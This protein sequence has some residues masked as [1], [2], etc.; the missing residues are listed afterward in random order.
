MPDPMEYSDEQEFMGVCVP[1]KVSEGMT[2]EDAAAQCYAMWMDKAKSTVK[3]AGDWE[4]EVLGVPFGSPTDKDSDGQY[5]S[6]HTD[7][8]AEQFPQI[9]AVYYHGR[10]PQ[11]RPMQKPEYF[12]TAKYAR[13]DERGHWYRVVLDKTKALAQRVWEA[14]KKGIARA[15]SGSAPHLVRIEND[16]HIKE[17]AVMELSIFDAEGQ[18][19]P[20]NRHAVAMPVLKALYKDAGIEFIDNQLEAQGSGAADNK[21]NTKQENKMSEQKEGLTPEMVQA[22]I[23]AALKAERDANEAAQKAQK[24]RDEEVAAE[25]KKQVDA[26]KAEYAK[27]RRL[28]DGDGVPYVTQF[29]DRKY[30]NLSA[31]ELSL[32]LDTLNARGVKPS[33]SAMKSLAL[34]LITEKPNNERRDK[35]LR[36]IKSAMPVQML[37]ENALK[38]AEVMATSDSGNGSDW[39]G[40]AYSTE[41][42]RSIRH[43]GGIVSRIPEVTIPDG[44]SS[45]YFPLEDADPTWYKVAETTAVNASIAVP[46][47]SVTAS[48]AGTA[49]KQ[50]TVSKL[51]A[52]VLYSGEMTEDSLIQFAPQ[53][54]EQLMVSGREIMEAI[55]INGDTETGA[56]TNI[57]DIAGTPAATDWFML[58][59]GFRKLALVTNTAN[60]RS[61]GGSLSIED[62]LETM[63]LLGTAGIAASDLSKI[64]F[65]VD[66]HVHFANM[67]LPEVKTRDVYSAAVIE[68][69]FLSQAYGVPILPSWQMNKGATGAYALKAN[70]A[71]KIDLDTNT[72]NTTGAIL[73]VRF[74][75]WKL[76]YKR[77]MTME[78]T[79]FANAD[80]WEIVA[81]ARFGLG[82]R[83]TEASAISYNVGI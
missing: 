7:I 40:T 66:P 44:Y 67:T 78:V 55:V 65:I 60:S 30:D 14:A 18:R 38:A 50:I 39:V 82:Y 34:K 3:A 45:Q 10:D 43:D 4:L 1:M 80:A 32:V 37:D 74:D 61:A 24:A 76:A 46:E 47:V 11:G 64:A 26:V 15:S 72:N 2:Q 6:K 81:L 57:N 52:R 75:Q 8:H 69:G 79:R 17:W 70:T 77:R 56:S 73:A 21:N 51:G 48:K 68:N 9:P 36:Y 31:G 35:D 63:K 59:N 71:G 5:F 23:A 16:G 49:N 58:T 13:T 22:Q 33:D 29:N 62:Y 19:Q 28:P 53:M 12:G 20:A 42:W 25:V 83:D 41:L 27:N 54:R